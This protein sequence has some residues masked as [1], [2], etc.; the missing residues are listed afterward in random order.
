MIDVISDLTNVISDLTNVISEDI[1]GAFSTAGLFAEW[2][3][4]TFDNFHPFVFPNI[5][6]ILVTFCKLAAIIR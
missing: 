5:I 3:G 2:K 6:V 1:S 4:H